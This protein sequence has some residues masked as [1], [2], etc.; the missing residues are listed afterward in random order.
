[1]MKK[2]ENKVYNIMI[3]D[4]HSLFRNGLKLLINSNKDFRVVSEASTGSEF[5]EKIDIIPV[6]I[7]LL[8]IS[9]PEMSGIEA[10]GLALRKQP[11]LKII[12][13]SMYGDEEYYYKMLEVGASG[14]LL[15][16]SDIDEVFTA[17]YHVIDGKNYF[18]QELLQNII[19]N[20]KNADEKPNE[21]KDLSER[22]IEIISLICKG[23][24]NSEIADK[25]CVSK[26]T[27]EKHRANILHKTNSKNTASLVV[28]AIKNNIVD[29]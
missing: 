21:I 27:V 24:S 29:V 10:A 19:N 12:T 28:F 11:D 7:V 15:K 25:I 9:M 4:D 5:I 13:L 3:V 26:R 22:E 14:F 1:M 16:E 23:L 20:I 18:S 6:D 2:Q 17:L 8:D